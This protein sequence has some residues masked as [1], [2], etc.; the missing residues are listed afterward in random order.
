MHVVY[1]YC[2]YLLSQDLHETPPWWMQHSCCQIFI[3]IHLSIYSPPLPDS[4]M[5]PATSARCIKVWYEPCCNCCFAQLPW[6]LHE[7]RRTGTF[8]L[9][10]FITSGF[11]LVDMSP[12][13]S[14]RDAE[15]G[16]SFNK[17]LWNGNGWTPVYTCWHDVHSL[18]NS[19]DTM[20]NRSLM[21]VFVP[22]PRH[23]SIA[24]YGKKN[25]KEKILWN[26]PTVD[27][28]SSAWTSSVCQTVTTLSSCIKSVWIALAW[29]RWCQ[30]IARVFI[31]VSCIIVL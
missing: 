6:E 4:T 31:W 30:C 8:L 27:L 11:A 3:S 29:S 26:F 17:A 22:P 23:R 28:P 18:H 2:L 9:V 13:G 19:Y 16:K 7:S 5:Y 14:E 25:L 10:F 12:L 21:L 24:S 1:L 15:W 20:D